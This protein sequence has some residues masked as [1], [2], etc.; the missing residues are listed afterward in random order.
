MRAMAVRGG[1]VWTFWPNPANVG[2]PSVLARQSLS[3]GDATELFGRTAN[4][5][6]LLLTEVDGHGRPLQAAKQQELMKSWDGEGMIL[7]P[8]GSPIVALANGLLYQALGRDRVRSFSP[9]GYSSA[10]NIVGGKRFTTMAAIADGAG[11]FVMA[12]PLGAVRVPNQGKATAIRFRPK[13][14]SAGYE[15]WG[16]T[17]LGD[18]GLLITSKGQ[19]Y[20]VQRNGTVVK[21]PTGKTMTCHP[22]NKLSDFGLPSRAQLVRLPDDTI[23]MSSVEKCNQVYGFRLPRS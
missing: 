20:R 2:N 11:G 3:G 5:K 22:T 13:I 4:G 7:P 6:H 23:A 1:D 19:L 10:L 14:P 21:V 9:D 16:A 12:G 15:G 8:T 17:S 18:G